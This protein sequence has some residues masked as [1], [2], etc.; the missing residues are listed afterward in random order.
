MDD[1]FK[2]QADKF[3]NWA[4]EK[5]V[6]VLIAIIIFFVGIKVAKLVVKLLKRIFD[7]R[8]VEKTVAHFT[9]SLVRWTIYVIT[10]IVSISVVGIQVTSLVTLLGSAGITLGF[11]LQGSLGNLAGGILILLLK[12]FKVGDYILENNSNTEG[13][14]ENIDI[15]YTKL[16]TIEDKLVVIPNG[17]L[18]NN[19]VINFTALE[20]RIILLKFGVAYD[21]DLNKVKETIMKV[22]KEESRIIDA[23]K[24]LIY[25][26]EYAESAIK[27]GLR[28][29]VACADYWPCRWAVM[30]NMKHAF[31]EAG[32]VIPFMQVVVH[33][34]EKMR[35]N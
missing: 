5:A 19:S 4:G 20:S 6:E 21:S 23:D 22:L 8:D 30:E 1:Y 28:A 25:V 33:E 35:L 15:F 9:L 3:L 2:N 16:R 18:T 13:V 12:P 34:G 31:D 29:R 17:T 14:V 11:A 27:F 10:F 32:I 7:R 24:S 26:D